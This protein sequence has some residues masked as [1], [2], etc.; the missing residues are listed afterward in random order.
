MKGSKKMRQ[1]SRDWHREDVKAAVRKRGTTI[2]ALAG[3]H[4]LKPQ[5]LLRTLV[6]PRE[7][8]ER[9]ISEF[10]GVPPQRIWPSRYHKDGRR[11]RPQPR[12]NYSIAN[13]GGNPQ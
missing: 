6:V 12:E 7:A 10:I 3:L 9:I 11:K 4:G 8:G 1:C 5:A 13:S 2:A